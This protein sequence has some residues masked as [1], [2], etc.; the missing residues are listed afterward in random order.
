MNTFRRF[1]AISLVLKMFKTSM[2]LAVSEVVPETKIAS[3]IVKFLI[4]VHPKPL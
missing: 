3:E 1:M 2:C 4:K